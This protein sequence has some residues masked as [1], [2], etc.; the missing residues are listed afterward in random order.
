MMERHGKYDLEVMKLK[1]SDCNGPSYTIS[2][3]E[4]RSSSVIN[5]ARANKAGA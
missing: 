3:A 4:E 5:F 2:R 1:E